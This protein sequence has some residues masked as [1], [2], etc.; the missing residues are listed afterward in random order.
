MKMRRR[1]LPEGWYPS[2]DAEI[3]ALLSEWKTAAP[4]QA[5]LA[6]VAP[7]AGWYFSGSVA[8]KSQ[9]SLAPADTVAVIGGHLPAD[10]PVL[11]GAEDAFE[12]PCGPLESDTALME[13]VLARLLGGKIPF[14]EDEYVDNSVE[15]QLPLLKAIF[16]D[17]GLLWLRAPASAAA[18]QALG[19]ALAGAAEELG[20]SLVCLASTD[21]THYGPDYDFMPKG[22]GP[23]AEKW[24]RSESDQG[25][26]DALLAMDAEKAVELGRAGAACSSG[27]AA[28]AV[29]FAR[30]K[31]AG[32]AV[33]NAHSMSLD[34][35]P[36][37]SFV[38][39]CSI[40]YY[41]T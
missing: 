6:A 20:R 37:P 27:A 24:A 30:L 16:P 9:L 13:K 31:G 19:S 41:R 17:A 21:L 15:V 28:A 36:A 3:R 40:S 1:T 22:R 39:Y 11:Y 10:Y 5:A 25:F 34:I 38:G 7:H 8:A 4:P 35:R 23:A 18:G 26:I 33:L 32:K 14:K 2:S 12:T 29:A